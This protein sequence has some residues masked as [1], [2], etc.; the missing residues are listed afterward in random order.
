MGQCATG[1]LLP[2]SAPIQFKFRIVELA[3]HVP[4]GR[5]A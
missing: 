3:D 2:V 5:V 1:D 4:V